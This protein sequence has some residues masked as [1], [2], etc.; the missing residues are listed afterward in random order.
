MSVPAIEPAIAAVQAAAAVCRH[1]QRSLDALRAMTKDDASPVTIGDFASQAVVARALTQAGI[2][3]RG[4]IAEESGAFLKQPEHQTHLEACLAALHESGA[5]PKP[6]ADDL[7][8]AVDLGDADPAALTSSEGGWTLDPIDGTKGFLRGEQYC[9]S[10]AF[11]RNG[12]VELGI[13]GCPNLAP[14][15]PPRKRRTTSDFHSQAGSISYALRSQGAFELNPE[16]PTAP[17]RLSLPPPPPPPPSPL[18]TPPPPPPP[19][20]PASPF[21]PPPPPT[22]PASPRASKPP[23]PARTSPPTS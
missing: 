6:T 12:A 14:T 9:I 22:P 17:N 18:T 21:P 20:H 5:W 7:I 4:L 16:H 19:P 11:I 8:A 13:L 15:S 2:M 1:V 3:R 10:L 23:T